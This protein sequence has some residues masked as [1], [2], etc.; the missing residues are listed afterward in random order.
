MKAGILALIPCLALLI[1]KNQ[2]RAGFF[3]F[4][5]TEDFW[6]FWPPDLASCLFNLVFHY[7]MPTKTLVTYI[8]YLSP[9]LLF[10]RLTSICLL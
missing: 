3:A 7:T 4:G 1:Q 5:G 10:M 9:F 2:P 8:S 6:W